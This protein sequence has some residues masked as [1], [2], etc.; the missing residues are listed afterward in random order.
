MQSYQQSAKFLKA[1]LH[2]SKSLLPILTFNAAK[3]FLAEMQ[4]KIFDPT[5]ENNMFSHSANPMLSMVLL[6]ELL[7]LISKK[8]FSL[9]YT[10][11]QLMEEVKK[12]AVEL[13]E[14]VDDENFLYSIMLEKD[15]A[16]RD[17]LAIAVEL[18]LLDLIT[19]PK[20]E[21]VV[22]R[23][24]NSDYDSSGSFFEMSSPY[25][26][27]MQSSAALVDVERASRFWK[28]RDIEGLPQYDSNFNI[29]QVSMYA[30]L[31]AMTLITVLYA[32]VCLFFFEDFYVNCYNLR[33][34]LSFLR[35]GDVYYDINDA[36][37]MDAGAAIRDAGQRAKH[38]QKIGSYA[39]NLRSHLPLMNAL[40][41][42]NFAFLVTH[43]TRIGF[44]AML[45]RSAP[46]PS[47]NIFADISLFV[48]S[49]YFSLW[50]RDVGTRF[51]VEIKTQ[52]EYLSLWDQMT[53]PYE[54]VLTVMVVALLLK[55]LDLIQFSATI[56]PLVKIV[57][58]MSGDFF[59][60]LALYAILVVMFAIVGCFNFMDAQSANGKETYLQLRFETLQEACFTV[61]D[62]SIGVYDLALFDN[63]EPYQK[64]LG[65]FFTIALVV[66]FKILILNLII[67]ILSNTYHQFDSQSGG[68]YLSKILN[69]RDELL[70][71]ENYGAFLLSL[72]PLSLLT[73]PALPVAIFAKPS[74]AINKALTMVQYCFFILMLYG[75]FLVGSALMLPFS[76]LRSVLHKLQAVTRSVETR[77]YISSSAEALF[78]VI[79]GLPL[80]F[81]CLLTDAYYFWLNNFRS[82]LKTIVIDRDVSLLSI[83]AIR[84]LKKVVAKFSAAKIRSVEYNHMSQIFRRKYGVENSIQYLI[85]G[86]EVKPLD[87]AVK[88]VAEEPRATKTKKGALVGMNLNDQKSKA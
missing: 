81:M 67:A 46:I 35:Y 16:G 69:S 48:A 42:T 85:F 11:R 55:V 83:D 13:I 44:L 21:A 56:G 38:L 53:F 74:E 18:E 43:V 80:L 72:P 77:E 6:Y 15:Y 58:K 84:E 30:R 10:C 5:L 73:I 49:L 8:F 41:Y 9:S 26:I 23:I 20:V 17:S 33:L 63:S 52:A 25:Q 64:H 65:Q 4:Y 19:A 68:L 34:E 31:K 78:F 60:F 1:K 71:D 37:K 61:L 70:H 79:F 62:A 75:M 59:N 36:L 40:T 14:A 2:L 76:F 82:E 45:G 7:A 51:Q 22:K 47:L 50:A 29:F 54:Y 39:E 12:L 87:K 27:L 86:Q 24:W 57:G 66:T 3:K 28:A 32:A 88:I